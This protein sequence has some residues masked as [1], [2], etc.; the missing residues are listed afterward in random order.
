MPASQAD[1]LA[2]T[3]LAPARGVIA[4]LRCT[5]PNPQT[6]RTQSAVRLTGGLSRFSLLKGRANY[7]TVVTPFARRAELRPSPCQPPGVCLVWAR[8]IA[9]R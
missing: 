4:A 2:I 5:F 1:L 9:Y 8:H 6:P 7:K 3:P